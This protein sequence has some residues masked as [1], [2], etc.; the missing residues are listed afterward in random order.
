[1]TTQLETNLNNRAWIFQ[2]NPL[3][4]DIDDALKS[5]DRIWWRVPQHTF[6]IHVGDIVVI[7]RSGKAAG[8]VG[9][10][11]VV[12]ELRLKAMEPS[13]ME[14]VRSEAS[15]RVRSQAW[16]QG[17][18]QVVIQTESEESGTSMQAAPG[19]WHA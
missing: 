15:Y 10:D 2:A 12:S 1:M 5:L 11:R 6:H 4:F 3:H 7:W 16:H 19:I 8:I 13:E 18:E 17:S 9:M 14:L